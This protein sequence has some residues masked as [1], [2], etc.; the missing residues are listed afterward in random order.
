MDV[1][2]PSSGTTLALPVSTP[3]EGAFYRGLLV[4]VAGPGG[5]I[6][7]LAAHWPARDGRFSLLLPSSVRGKTLRFWESDFASFSRSAATPGGAVDLGVW[8]TKLSPRT[9]R[10]VA[11]LT[12]GR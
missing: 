11:F 9:A 4:G 1:K 5:V 3:E 6:K 10:D 8:P 2:L 12:V 7:P